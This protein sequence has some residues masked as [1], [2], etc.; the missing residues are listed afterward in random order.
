MCTDHQLREQQFRETAIT[1][2]RALMI[3]LLY[4]ITSQA[5]PRTDFCRHVAN[6]TTDQKGEGVWRRGGR[7][8]EGEWKER[9]S[10]ERGGWGERQRQRQTDRQTI[11]GRWKERES[12]ERGGWGET[13]RQRL[14]NKQKHN[15]STAVQDQLI[16]KGVNED[17]GDYSPW[18]LLA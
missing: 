10:G 5:T 7:A 11:E 8:I 18:Y 14:K 16:N 3:P 9:E 12:G 17:D 13:D 1:K 15:N 6:T 2:F 4:V